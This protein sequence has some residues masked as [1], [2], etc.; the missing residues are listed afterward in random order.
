VICHFP[1]PTVSRRGIQI[2]LRQL[3]DLASA[4]IAAPRRPITAFSS[5]ADASV[6]AAH[7]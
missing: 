7:A 4:C 2:L 1:T 3:V 5:L 6:S